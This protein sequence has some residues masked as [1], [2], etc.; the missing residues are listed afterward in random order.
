MAPVGNGGPGF[1]TLQSPADGDSVL[2]VG[3][4][5]P[6]G[7][8]SAFSA[9]GPTADG[10]LKPDLMA[11]GEALPAASGAGSSSS[12]SFRAPSSPAHFWPGRRLCLSRRTRSGGPWVSPGLVGIGEL[13]RRWFPRVPRVAPAILFPDGVAALPLQERGRP[14]PGDE[15]GTSVSMECPQPSPPR[16]TGDLPSGSSPKIPCFRGSCSRDSVVG[17]FARRLQA[18]LPP[19]TRVFWRVTARSPQ[20]IGLGYSCPGPL[21]GSFLGYAGRVERPRR[22]PGRR[23]LSR[24]SAG[25]PWISLGWPGLSSSSYRFSRIG[26]EELLQSYS[27]LAEEHHKIADPLPFNLPLRWR[28]IATGLS[29]PSRIRWPAPVHSW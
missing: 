3:A 29:G 5:N 6:S 20:G 4:V 13:V 28:V 16:V 12:P 22:D 19:R 1:Q 18:P 23:S 24:S 9:E 26:K 2:A 25:R 27:G 14:G 7:I 15:P 21:R 17:T 8:R 10:R 11:P